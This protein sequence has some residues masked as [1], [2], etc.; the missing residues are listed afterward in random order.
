VAGVVKAKRLLVLVACL[1][2]AGGCFWRSYPA[3][4]RTH[5]ELLVSFA[6]KTGDLV[7]AH[8]FTAQNLPELT[9][10]LERATAFARETRRHTSEAPDSLVA[11]ERLLER[12]RELLYLADSTRQALDAS[13]NVPFAVSAV[14][15]AGD[16]VEAA[17]VREGR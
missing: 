17:L 13:Q 6:R 10:P 3:R 12:Y 15:T 4:M 5:T 11:F 14:G 1:A 16:A 8:R 9:Y 2:M 7:E